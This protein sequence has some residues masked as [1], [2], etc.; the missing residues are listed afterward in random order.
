[1]LAGEKQYLQARGKD[2]SGV[3]EYFQ[4][5][6][7]SLR[8]RCLKLSNADKF[9]RVGFGP[10]HLMDYQFFNNLLDDFLTWCKK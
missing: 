10:L 9:F 2:H 5:H 6:D 8:E 1:M 4:L 7:E 3:S